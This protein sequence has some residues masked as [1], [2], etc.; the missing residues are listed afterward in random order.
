MFASALLFTATL[1][2]LATAI[3]EGDLNISLQVASTVASANNLIVTAI[4]SNPTSEDIRVLAINNVLD[5]SPTQSFDIKSGDGSAVPF[6]GAKVTWDLSSDAIYK[7]IPAGQSVAVNHTIGGIHD[8]SSFS[9]GTTF[10]VTPH[11]FS[12]I[13]SSVKDASGIVPRA[14]PVNFVVTDNTKTDQLFNSL[15]PKGQPQPALSTPTCSDGTK[16][17]LI[18]D[19]LAYARSL[20][21]GAATDINSHPN[22]AEYNRYFGGNTQS[23]IW[24]NFDRIAGDLPSAGTRNIYCASD[25]A[26]SRDA[27]N[28]NPWIAYTVI[29]SDGRTPIYTCDG[30]ANCGTTP[31][32]CSSRNYDATT[33]SR[34]GVILHELAHAVFGAAD[35]A[36]GCSATER[37]GAAD[38]R[39]NADNYRCMGL[40][41]YLDYNC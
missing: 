11:A 28:N 31:S 12:S 37:L 17:Q 14:D 3:S 33:S 29:Y 40:N 8:F 35:I 19:S 34:G 15:P 20:A 21:G 22:G 26:D 38:R 27:C 4:V 1:A 24:Y 41:I 18:K 23:D 30:L 16:L 2:K 39:N 9:A 6:T 13:L 10:E 32:I 36:Y 5:N 7:N 25:Y